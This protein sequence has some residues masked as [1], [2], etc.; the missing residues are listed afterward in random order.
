MTDRAALLIE[1]G[2]EELP[3][4]SIQPM[5]EALS[6]QL[7]CQLSDAGFDPGDI[8][9]YATP[10]RLAVLIQNVQGQQADREI[11]KRG[12]AIQAAF[13]GEGNPSKA[14]HGFAKSCGVDFD[15]LGR[16]KTDKGEW[17]AYNFT[18]KGEA[19][20]TQLGPMLVKVINGL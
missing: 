20:N 14:A 15:A 1:L 11:E 9:T 3:A 6:K 7:H 8:K 17:L 12:P 2:C 19:L 4:A 13:D 16:L 10:R 5:A 18:Q